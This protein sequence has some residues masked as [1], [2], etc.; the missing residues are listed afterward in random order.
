MC[1]ASL[2]IVVACFWLL[3]MLMCDLCC[4]M[5]VVC[6]LLCVAVCCVVF[7]VLGRGLLVG[8]VVV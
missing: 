7:A 1:C 2:A 8:F 3:S 6:C 4:L 5:L